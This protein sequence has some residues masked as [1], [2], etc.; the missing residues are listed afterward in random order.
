M[1]KL[2]HRN[3]KNFPEVTQLI[4]GRGENQREALCS[5]YV[6]SFLLFLI[7]LKTGYCEYDFLDKKI[8]TYRGYIP[9]SRLRS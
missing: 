5:W 6:L 2:R 1:K 7:A 9:F 4:Y 3:V 8:K